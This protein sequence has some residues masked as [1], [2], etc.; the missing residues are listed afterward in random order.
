MARVLD[1]MLRTITEDYLNTIDP[2]NP[3]DPAMVQ[4]EILD[5]T[6]VN[7]QLENAVR[8]KGTKWKI[9][10]RLVPSQLALILE[11]LHNVVNIAYSGLDGDEEYD[12][13]SIYQS[14][15]PDMGI[16]SASKNIF[17]NMI[18]KYCFTATDKEVTETMNIL[19]SIVKRVTRNNDKN[20][21]A[22][23]NGIFDYDTKQLLPFSPDLVFI[24]KSRVDYNPNAVNVVKT[25]PDGTKWDV[26]SWIDDLFD[27]DAEMVE[28]IWQIIGAIIRPNVPWN[29][30]AWFYS[31]TGNNGKGTLCELMRQITGRG[32]YTS[33]QLADFSKDFMLEPLIHSTAII[34]DE[35]DVG[36]YVDKAANL[37]AVITGDPIQINRKFKSPIAYQFKGFMIQCLNEMPR[38]KDKSES[39]Y[40]RQLLVPFTKCF[41]G[42]ERK[43][44]KDEYLKDKDVLEYVLHRVLH[45]NYYSLLEPATCK[46][47]LEEYK[48]YNDPLREFLNDILPKC[49][50]D[51]LPYKFLFAL[52][53]AW[54]RTNSPS[55]STLGRIK[56]IKGVKSF[57][58][59][60]DWEPTSTSMRPAHRMDAEEPLA[61]EYGLTDWQ[62][63]NYKKAA[64]HNGLIRKVQTTS[65]NTP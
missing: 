46:Q 65:Q 53:S 8:E 14:D 44:I 15:G 50:W 42:A 51:L 22:V 43:Y 57:V 40:R 41:T 61:R 59:G 58:A 12:V 17:R 37:K 56:F 54:L 35:N 13:L 34:V 5:A 64:N 30:S 7:F 23:N 33:I 63:S 60:T 38:I 49:V 55:S 36:L 10:N 52:Y 24:S 21:I 29:K 32:T 2:L 28:L 16:Y 9:P 11:T 39:F 45:S 31:E 3:P 25:N 18:S 1:E 6:M 47:A 62:G 27:G 20:L 26:E 48:G 4:A 19:R